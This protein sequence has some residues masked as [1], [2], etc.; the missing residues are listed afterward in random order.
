M[1]FEVTALPYPMDAL[2]P[3][4]SSK[5]IDIHYNLH[6]KGYMKKL[7]AAIDTKP[8]A[9]KSLEEIVRTSNGDVFNNAAQVYNHT[10]FWNSM[11]PNSGGAPT[12]GPVRDLLLR[13]FGSWNGFRT[14][15]IQTGMQQFGSGWTWFVLNGGHGEIISTAN[16]ETPLTSR[17]K[18]LLT[19]DV[20][21]HAYY[22]DYQ[23]KRESFLEIFCDH[24][25]NWDFVLENMQA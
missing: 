14:R 6:H 23:N 25:I 24:L 18:P 21:E 1:Y 20:W 3:H 12:A 8:D 22:L 2:E 9:N 4:I 7:R 10:F 15:F 17:S 5:T 16:A 13:D 19:A 11:K